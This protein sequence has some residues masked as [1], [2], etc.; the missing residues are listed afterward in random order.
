MKPIRTVEEAKKLIE[1]FAGRAEEFEL[2]ISDELQ[3]PVGANMAIITVYIL[4]KGWEPNGFDQKAGFR[5]YRYKVLGG[6]RKTD[7]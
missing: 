7:P 3:D 4:K 1:S 6:G 2:P 5:I